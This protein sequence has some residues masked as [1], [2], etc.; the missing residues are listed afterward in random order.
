MEGTS[1]CFWQSIK[2]EPKHEIFISY[3]C[4]SRTHLCEVQIFLQSSTP[5]EFRFKHGNCQSNII[6]IYRSR[7][8]FRDKKIIYKIE[9]YTLTFCFCYARF[10]SVLVFFLKSNRTGLAGTSTSE[11]LFS[12]VV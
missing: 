9:I 6:F 1:D 8:K 2:S 12:I 3:T 7:R 4:P 11:I 5:Y 10:F